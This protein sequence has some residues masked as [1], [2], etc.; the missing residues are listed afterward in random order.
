MTTTLHLD[1]PSAGLV[2][3][4]LIRTMDDLAARAILADHTGLDGGA[5]TAAEHRRHVATLR[6]VLDQLAPDSRG[7]DPHQVAARWLDG[8]YTIV[9][10]TPVKMLAATDVHALLN[11][12][13]IDVSDLD[14]LATIITN[15]LHEDPDSSL[16]AEHD[17]DEQ[18]QQHSDDPTDHRTES[19]LAQRSTPPTLSDS[20]L[21]DDSRPH[22]KHRLAPRCDPT[23]SDLRGDTED[24]SC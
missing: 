11:I 23:H 19:D 17:L 10:H 2:V 6:A 9:D 22:P 8:I 7:P 12:F 20:E 21:S 5:A 16:E 18:H 14:L 3:H 13:G 15:W 1:G 24:G 4:A